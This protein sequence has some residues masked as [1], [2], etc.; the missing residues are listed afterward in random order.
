MKIQEGSSWR[1]ISRRLK[2][3]REKPSMFHVTFLILTGGNADI[4]KASEVS[5]L[6]ENISLKN[7]G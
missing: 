6:S 1:R 5:E 7:Q 3:L 2:A 4:L